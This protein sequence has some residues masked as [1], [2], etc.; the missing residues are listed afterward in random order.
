MC[1]SSRFYEHV[2]KK[3]VKDVSFD[4]CRGEIVGIAGVEGNGQSELAR[5]L[6]GLE[7]I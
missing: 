1:Q 3:A 5:M 6:T 4:V 7:E 2:R